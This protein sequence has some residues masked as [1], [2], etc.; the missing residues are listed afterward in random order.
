MQE[1]RNQQANSCCCYCLRYIKTVRYEPSRGHKI[2]RSKQNQTGNTVGE[3]NRESRQTKMDMKVA[4]KGHCRQEGT[5]KRQLRRVINTNK[6]T[7][8]KNTNKT[9]QNKANKTQQHNTR[10]ARR[11]SSPVGYARKAVIEIAEDNSDKNTGGG[12]RGQ[13]S[14][15]VREWGIEH[16]NG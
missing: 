15:N 2:E 10:W 16:R 5:Q 6:Q 4:R 11:T 8:N 1:P 14:N 13:Q 12:N 9:K 7:R 3:E